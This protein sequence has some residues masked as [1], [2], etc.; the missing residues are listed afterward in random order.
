MAAQG[1][2][3]VP[4][5]GEPD[6]GYLD[7]QEAIY[8][9]REAELLAAHPDESIVV[10]GE[11]V[12]VGGSDGEAVSRAQ[13]AHPGR[14]F[15]LRACRRVP[16][17]SDAPDTPDRAAGAGDDAFEEDL[18]RQKSIFLD[19]ADE[20]LARHPDMFIAV[21]GGDVF[22]GKDDDEAIAKAHASHPGRPFFLRMYDPCL[23]C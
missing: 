20:L 13:A 1:L 15:F 7:R 11:E 5:G 6:P 23:G 22:V 14:P 19:R 12:F 18:A 9:G 2:R 16:D 8:R 21:C 4:R 10:C 3:G 17:M